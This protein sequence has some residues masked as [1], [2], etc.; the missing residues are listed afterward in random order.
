MSE[1]QYY[2]WQTLDR[3]LTAAEQKA[4]NE[5]SSHI[6]VTSTQAIVTYNWSSFKHNPINVLANYFDAH[7]Y[8]ANWGTRRLAFRFPKGLVDIPVIDS[9]CDEYH[10]TIKTIDDV[11]VLEFEMDEE[12]GYDEWIE[13]RGLLSTLAR[14][15]D[16]IIQGDYRALYLA[17]LNAMS[18]ESGGYEEE[19]D[20]PENFF[21]DPEP[22]LPTGLKQL[23]P[24]LKALIDF[25]DIDP[26]LV[27]AAAERSLSLSS[28][29]QADFAPLISRL[30]RRECD[31]FLLK[32]VNA[33]PGAVAALRKRLLSFEKPSPNVQ[34]NPRTFGELLKTAE[35][36]RQVEARRQA[37][38]IGRRH[39]AEMQKLAKHEAK[40]WQDV[41]DLIQSGY[42]ASN[43]DEATILL[44]KLHQ[45]A[46]FQGTQIRFDVQLQ[47]LVEK[48]KSR[49]ALVGRWRKKGWI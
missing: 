32:I 40:T 24:P 19:E 45:L 48:Y 29:G 16:D 35:K 7:L 1:Y 38:E 4:V 2:E 21:N 28:A 18:Q 36:L 26:F 5:L 41:E 44:V 46:E 8:L 27:S 33:E 23:T 20:D 34:S 39:V 49:S 6:N 13:E 14:L 15:R 10:T 9:Y 3:P 25:F 31:E 30:T 11:Q 22:S 47:E 43:Y 12:G 37:E 42:A 17:W